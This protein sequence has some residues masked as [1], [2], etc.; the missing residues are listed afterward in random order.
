V[1][2]KALCELSNVEMMQ[3]ISR[4]VCDLETEMAHAWLLTKKLP[5]DQNAVNHLAF[6]RY[7]AITMRLPE[8]ALVTK[9]GAAV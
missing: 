2:L 7:L 3:V 9:S 1:N 6:G 5:T 4:Q 8:H